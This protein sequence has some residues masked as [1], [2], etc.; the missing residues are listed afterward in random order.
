M[1]TDKQYYRVSINIPDV[2]GRIKPA[3]LTVPAADDEHAREIAL[4]AFSTNW[5][6]AQTF[7]IVSVTP[8]SPEENR[9]RN[10]QLDL[11]SKENT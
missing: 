3:T 7:N 6:T 11:F 1:T 10:A 8:L 5:P 2:Y 9:L 4:Y